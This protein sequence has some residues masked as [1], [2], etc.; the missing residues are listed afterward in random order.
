MS[1]ALR[2]LSRYV[3]ATIEVLAYII[4]R[5]IDDVFEIID[6]KGKLIFTRSVTYIYCTYILR[7]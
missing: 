7:L 2:L 1:F 3:V 6:F 5:N 4:L